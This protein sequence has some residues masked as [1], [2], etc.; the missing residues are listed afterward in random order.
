MKTPA[1]MMGSPARLLLATDLSARCDRALERAAQL[2]EK[3]QAELIALNVLEAPQA[4]DLVLAWAA[5]EDDETSNRIARKQL[6]Q[7][8]DGLDVRASMRVIRG[9]PENIIPAVANESD[10]GLIVTGMARNETFGRFLT[11]NTVESLARSVPQPLLVVRNRVRGPYRRMIVATDFSESSRHA[12]HAATRFFPECEVIVYHAATG[13][14]STLPSD[15]GAQSNAGLE[16]AKRECADFLAAS[17]LPT[18][19]RDRL[20]MVIEPGPLETALAR[21]VREQNVDMV[22]IGTY[23][24][25][26]LMNILLGSTAAKL[27]D[28][29]PCDTLIVRTP[30]DAN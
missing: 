3:W 5:H 21:Y 18:E 16:I 27:L 1:W 4:P 14:M 6:R 24:R 15:A 11:G 17:D 19:V 12:L 10:C 28:W 25:N 13:P 9:E 23:G 8:L 30:R 26:D 29:L 7:D 22:A 20:Q 2:A